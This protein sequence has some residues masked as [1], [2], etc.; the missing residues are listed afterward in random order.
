MRYLGIDYGTKRVGIALSDEGA[1]MAFPKGVVRN[2]STLVEDIV[3]LCDEESVAGV[4]IGESNKLDG[5]PNPL[6]EDINR[7]IH[8]WKEKTQ[9]PISLHPEFLTSHQAQQVTGKNDMIDASAA[10][11]I[12][13]SYLD[14]KA[15]R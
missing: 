8:K 13:Q 3:Y 11:I 6:M 14:K 9:I 10:A 15:H 2:T 12:L 1:S 5:T 7:F 4:V